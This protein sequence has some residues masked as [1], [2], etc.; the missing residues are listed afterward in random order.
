MN[1]KKFKE[2]FQNG[3]TG[4]SWIFNKLNLDLPEEECCFKHDEQYAQG[5]T[6]FEKLLAD[7]KLAKCIYQK[8][9]NKL[10]GG[11]RAA[12]GIVLT[13]VIPYSYSAWEWKKEKK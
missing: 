5:G 8:N 1:L 11:V 2:Q 3:C 4:I 13:V 6:M 10:R 7:F 9:K 12:L